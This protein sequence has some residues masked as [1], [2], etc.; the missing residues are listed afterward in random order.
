LAIRAREP[1]YITKL[2][3][4]LAREFRVDIASIVRQDLAAT[5][6]AA[7]AATAAA[8]AAA[9]ATA[10][11]DAMVLDAGAGGAGPNDA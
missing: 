6:A 2:L 1:P 10:A 7:A 8:A 3:D 11:A 9:A 4:N 5:S